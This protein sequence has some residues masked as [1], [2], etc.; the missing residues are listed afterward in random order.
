MFVIQQTYLIGKGYTKATY[1]FSFWKY[2]KRLMNTEMGT[3]RLNE[4]FDHFVV[5]IGAYIGEVNKNNV[6]QDF[7]WKEFDSV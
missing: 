3:R 5:R 6:K 2:A 7:Y 4:Y 1:F